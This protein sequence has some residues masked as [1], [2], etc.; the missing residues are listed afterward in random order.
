M[1][2]VSFGVKT[3]YSSNKNRQRPEKTELMVL[4]PMVFFLVNSFQL[5]N[6]F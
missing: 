2:S 5:F 1:K 4:L 6:L 3:I